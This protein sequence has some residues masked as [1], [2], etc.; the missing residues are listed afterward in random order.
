MIKLDT[1]Y[2][3]LRKIGVDLPQNLRSQLEKYV[4]KHQ[5]GEGDKRFPLL[6]LLRDMGLPAQTLGA[7]NLRAQEALKLLSKVE[8]EKCHNLLIELKKAI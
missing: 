7:E 6:R 2:T 5:K 1:L 8:L 3:V 4:L